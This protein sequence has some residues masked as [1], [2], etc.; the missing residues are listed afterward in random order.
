M[1]EELEKRMD[2][3]ESKLDIIATNHLKH[4][5]RYTLLTLAGIIV[6]VAIGLTAVWLS[7]GGA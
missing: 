5:E 2:T 6:S 7:I 1:I 4:I 3:I